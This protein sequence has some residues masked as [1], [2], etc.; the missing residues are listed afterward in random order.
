MVRHMIKNGAEYIKIMV[1]ELQ[2]DEMEAAI[3]TAHQY[4]LSVTGDA[5]EPYAGMAGKLGIDAIEH[6][7]S[8]TDE[9]LRIMAEQ[10][11]FYAPTIV[12]NL[13]AE[14]IADRE[15]LIAELDLNEDPDVLKG[16]VLVAYAD[17]RSPRF[18]ATQRDV[19]DR[20]MKAGVRI[21]T[22]GDSNPVGEIGL[23]EIEMLVFS[24][25]R[26]MDALIAATRNS[27]EMNGKLDDLG[28]L[29]V[30]KIADLIV[31][32]GDPLEHISNIRKLEMVFKDGVPV[33]LA[34]DEGQTSFW[35]LF[36]LG[37]DGR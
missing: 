33:N 11:T 17:E 14:Y 32:S 15:R 23:L 25:M 34:R 35:E 3:V 5:S 30:G 7:D 12:C 16:R 1:N 19:L 21:V 2:P 28:T 6:G 31:L 22:G 9:T 24:G 10:G 18:A 36:L 20:A 27:A 29:E 37:A 4:G 8:L 13:S 26:E